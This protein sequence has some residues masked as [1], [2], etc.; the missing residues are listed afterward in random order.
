[1][2]RL[3][4]EPTIGHFQRAAEALHGAEVVSVQLS[5][6]Q[7]ALGQYVSSTHLPPGSGCQV[8]IDCSQQ[9][10]GAGDSLEAAM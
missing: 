7:A 2:H 5:G 4:Q 10:R 9:V 3:L 6:S 8:K 1:M